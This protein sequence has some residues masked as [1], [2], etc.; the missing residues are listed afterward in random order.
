MPQTRPSQDG[1]VDD[2]DDAGDDDDD[3][4]DDDHD[5]YD[6]DDDVDDVDTTLHPVNSYISL[7]W[8]ARPRIAIAAAAARTRGGKHARSF[9]RSSIACALHIWEYIG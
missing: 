1:C 4:D 3:G 6:D 7:P 2:D 9:D 8:I 5:L